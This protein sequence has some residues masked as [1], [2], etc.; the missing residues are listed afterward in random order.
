VARTKTIALLLCLSGCMVNKTS[1]FAEEYRQCAIVEDDVARQLC[2]T[3]VEAAQRG[4]EE[5]ENREEQDNRAVI[6]RM[7][8]VTGVTRCKSE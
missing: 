2:L 8:Y 3:R 4:Q 5:Q 6:C 7:D 1:R